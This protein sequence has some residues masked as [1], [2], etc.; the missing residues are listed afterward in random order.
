MRGVIR[1]FNEK[2]AAV[3][4]SVNHCFRLHT[5]W[6]NRHGPVGLYTVFCLEFV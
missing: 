4:G 5:L 3:P 6:A 1:L 2:P